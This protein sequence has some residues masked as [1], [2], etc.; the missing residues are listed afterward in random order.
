[1]DGFDTEINK[2]AGIYRQ[3]P[4]EVV[5]WRRLDS[6]FEV[7]NFYIYITPTVIAANFKHYFE[8]AEKVKNGSLAQVYN[9]TVLDD[10]I[11]MHG[12]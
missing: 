7:W 1:M 4:F 3:I 8:E 6:D 11:D 10:I 2:K 12:G 9:Y 5:K